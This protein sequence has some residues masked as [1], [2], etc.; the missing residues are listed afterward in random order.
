MPPRKTDAE[1]RPTRSGHPLDEITESRTM[2]RQKMRVLETGSPQTPP[3]CKEANCALGPILQPEWISPC[4]NCALGPVLQPEWTSPYTN[5]PC[6]RSGS[7]RKAQHCDTDRSTGEHKTHGSLILFF[8]FIPHSRMCRPRTLFSTTDLLFYSAL[9]A[10]A[11]VD[12]YR[13]L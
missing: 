2:L 7:T 6:S 9:P 11:D 4:M 10:F 1:N 5:R 12:P 8:G 13:S 3:T